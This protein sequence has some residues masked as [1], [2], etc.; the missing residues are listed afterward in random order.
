[1]RAVVQRVTEARVEVGR[2]ITGAIGPGLLVLLGVHVNDTEADAEWMSHKLL[3]L[4]ILADFEDKMNES[5][6]DQ[7]AEILVVSQF[8]LYGDARKGFRPSFIEAARPEQGQALY[9][10]VVAKLAD[11]LGHAV[12]TGEF[13]AMMQVHLINDGPVTIVLESPQSK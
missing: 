9:E 8:T 1:M 7:Q 10:S 13:G 6:L 3:N 12:P 2:S 11:G 4:R 5:I